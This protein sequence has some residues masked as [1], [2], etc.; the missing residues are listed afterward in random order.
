MCDNMA[1][2]CEAELRWATGMLGSCCDDGTSRR[3]GFYCCRLQQFL[4]PAM[5]FFPRGRSAD[6]ENHRLDTLDRLRSTQYGLMPM[7]DS[8]Y[9]PPYVTPSKNKLF[10]IDWICRFEMEITIGWGNCGTPVRWPKLERYKDAEHENPFL[11][12][13]IFRRQFF[14]ARNRVR[15]SACGEIAKVSEFPKMRQKSVIKER[16]VR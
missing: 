10:V 1:V 5:G 8:S 4:V 16:W 11:R 3:K 7:I 6:S 13:R 12:R 14:G 2:C 9:A 15:F